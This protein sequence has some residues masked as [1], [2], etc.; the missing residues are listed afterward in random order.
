MF[1]YFVFVS[2]EAE[3]GSNKASRG[4]DLS[5]RGAVEKPKESA[6]HR[7]KKRCIGPGFLRMMWSSCEETFREQL[8]R[9]LLS[10]VSV[11]PLL[12]SGLEWQ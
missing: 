11:H 12:Q 8:T 1:L 10:P 5:E 4:R 9:T 6:D 3:E 7:I 2:Q